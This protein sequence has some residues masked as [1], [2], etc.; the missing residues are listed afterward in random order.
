[1]KAIPVVKVDKHVYQDFILSGQDDE[2]WLKAYGRALEGKEN[3]GVTLGDEVLWYNGRLWV[4]DSV[5]LRTMILQEECDCKVAGHM[6]QE[7]T[8]ELVRRNLFWP[9]MD[10]WI[11]NY[12]RCC[13]DSQRTNEV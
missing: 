9:Q 5:D 6:G 1:L 12:A 7:K 10:Q 4:P 11:K 8:I 13:P 2:D 3:A